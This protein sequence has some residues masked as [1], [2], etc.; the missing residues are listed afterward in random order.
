MEYILDL[1]DPASF[2]FFWSLS[3]FEPWICRSWDKLHTHVPPCLLPKCEQVCNLYL[4][5]LICKPKDTFK[6]KTTKTFH[7]SFL[8]TL[9]SNRKNRYRWATFAATNK[10]LRYYKTVYSFGSVLKVGNFWYLNW[11]GG[12]NNQSKVKKIIPRIKS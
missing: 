5:N 7:S 6:V 8:E 2:K 9:V 4:S 3:R 10:I 11:L 1:K 12:L